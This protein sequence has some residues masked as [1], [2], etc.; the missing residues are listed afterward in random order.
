MTKQQQNNRA[1][2]KFLKEEIFIPLFPA[3]LLF[4]CSAAFFKKLLL[5]CSTTLL[6]YLCLAAQ[7]YAFNI[8]EK[9]IYDLTWTGIKAGEAELEIKDNGDYLSIISKANSSKWVS[10]FYHVEDIVISKLKKERYGNF[11]ASPINYRLK[12]K[13]GK[14]RRDKELIFDHSVNK[15]TYINH[16]DNER[17]DFI[18]GDSTYDALSCFYYVRT[19][20]LE[21]GKSVFVNLFDSKKFY[22]VEVQVLR[23]EAVR[24]PLGSF[25][26][27]L[28]K[29]IMKSEG[30]FSRKGDI[31]I[32]LSD[33]ERR[34]PLMLQSKVAV[35]SIKAVLV[36]IQ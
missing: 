23:K 30:I 17:K 35:G 22:S 8:P 28:I 33:D 36:R 19:L 31:L 16:L 15:V 26:A 25:D 18:I 34:I 1:D 24:I 14:H 11:F 2:Q 5:C 9:L 21:V 29:P 32:W 7:T 13:E 6:L 27:I 3:A 20:P 4:Y 10:V 12:I